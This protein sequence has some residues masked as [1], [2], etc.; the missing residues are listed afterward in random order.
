MSSLTTTISGISD[1]DNTKMR[2]IVLFVLLSL[3]TSSPEREATR[4]IETSFHHSDKHTGGFGVRPNGNVTADEKRRQGG[5]LPTIFVT[6]IQKGGS[7]SL[8][9]LMI[10]HPLLCSGLHKEMHFFDHPENYVRGT[11]FYRQMY[12][13]PKCDSKVGSRFIDATPILHYPSTWQRIYDTYSDSPDM[14]D[15]LKFIVL[16]REPVAR[17]YS[18]YQHTVRTGSSCKDLFIGNSLSEF[19]N[20]YYGHLLIPCQLLL[21]LKIFTSDKYS[22]ASRR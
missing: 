17:D 16:L 8:Y 14:R 10:N 2:L 13:D 11:N 5:T 22:P 6:G 18:W 1:C 15:N 20:F 9:E 3:C 4:R 19:D 21:I 7:S 12:I